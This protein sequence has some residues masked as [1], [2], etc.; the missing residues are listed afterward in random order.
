[1]EIKELI[2]KETLDKRIEELA[3]QI[4]KD[5][6][7]Q[8][9]VLVSVLNGATFFSIELSLKMKSKIKNEFMK[10]SS[11][12][13]TESTGKI[14]KQLDIDKEKI[15]GKN[16]LIVEDIID[17]GRSM[18]YLINYFKERNAKD[19]KVC[20]LLSKPSRREMDVNIDYLGFE[21]Q[22]KFIVGFG[23]DDENGFFRNLPYIGY[24]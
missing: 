8:E 13:G 21:V 2:K 22:D 6:N 19:I 9:I 20:T 5:Y 14:K 17:T 15:I 23:L 7:G 1:M 12:E 16:I 4:D 11:Y 24:K 3:N 10:I 18:N